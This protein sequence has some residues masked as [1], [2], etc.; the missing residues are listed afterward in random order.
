MKLVQRIVLTYYVLKLKIIERFSKTTAAKSAFELFC[1]PYTRSRKLV[2]PKVF[3]KAENLSILFNN[4]QLQGYRWKP[5]KPNG[6]RLLICHGFD[7]MSYKYAY[8][9]EPLLQAGF[10][11]LAFD[12]PAHGNSSGKTITALLY[13]DAIIH[14]NNLYGTLDIIMAHS[15]GCIAASLAVEQ[16]L[17][18]LQKLVLIAPATETTRSIDDF[19]K[20]L[21]LSSPLKK[22]MENLIVEIGG[23]DPSWYSVARIV[24]TLTIKTLWLHDKQDTITPYKDMEYLTNIPL[25]NV[26]FIITT[27][28]GHSLYRKKEV[29]DKILEWMIQSENKKT[30]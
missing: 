28:M 23:K 1:T 27:G 17:T 10:E 30:S 16:S 18:S 15:F 11:V 9:I 20:F 5:I 26:E 19:A 24:K 7:S 2:V 29:A 21:K 8:F 3:E 13:K 14:L 25:P 4:L 6:Q 22:A 12:A